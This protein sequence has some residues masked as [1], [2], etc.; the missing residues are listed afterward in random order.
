MSEQSQYVNY[1]NSCELD[2]E[3]MS[4]F[5]WRIDLSGKMENFSDDDRQEV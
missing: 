2:E 3:P 1:I 4:F 5:D